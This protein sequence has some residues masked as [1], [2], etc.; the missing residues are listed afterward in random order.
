MAGPKYIATNLLDSATVTAPGG[1]ATGSAVANLYAM[2]PSL[3][4]ISSVTTANQRVNI[5]HGSAVDA[6]TCIIHNHNF[7]AG[8][9]VVVE[10][11]SSAPPTSG[12]WSGATTLGTF[13]IRSP[14][15]W[16]DIGAGSYSYR[17]IYLQND[18]TA[19]W[20]AAPKIGELVLGDAVQLTRAF[21]WGAKFDLIARQIRHQTPNGHVWMARRAPGTWVFSLSWQVLSKSQKDELVTLFLAT[22]DAAVPFSVIPNPDVAVVADEVFYVEADPTFSYTDIHTANKAAS[23][24]LRELPREVVLS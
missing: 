8:S 10:G 2:D 20:A 19:A 11:H 9:T 3:T 18:G 14:D 6:D 21:R 1:T 17:S 24:V 7:P 12:A 13:T 5:D 16:L 15:M 22:A 4:W 23:L